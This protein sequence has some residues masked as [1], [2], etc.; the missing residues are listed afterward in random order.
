MA[1]HT[2][3]R[4]GIKAVAGEKAVGGIGG[5]DAPIEEHTDRVGIAGTELHIVGDHDDGDALLL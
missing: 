4:R 5:D 2:V 1:A 3:G